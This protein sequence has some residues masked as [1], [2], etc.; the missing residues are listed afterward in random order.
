MAKVVLPQNRILRDFLQSGVDI[1]QPRS[2]CI[3]ELHEFDDCRYKL[4]RC[5]AA[6]K[7]ESQDGHICFCCCRVAALVWKQQAS[8]LSCCSAESYTCS[9]LSHSRFP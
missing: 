8:C 6:M 3:A 2:S 4:E 9:H 1:E 7:L 5:V